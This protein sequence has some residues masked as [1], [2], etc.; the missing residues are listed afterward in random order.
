MNQDIYIYIYNIYTVYTHHFLCYSGEIE[1]QLRHKEN[2]LRDK[3]NLLREK[4][5]QLRDEKKQLWDERK[6]VHLK[7]PSEGN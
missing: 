7:K 5:K 6:E 3:E 1:K 4:E 2:L